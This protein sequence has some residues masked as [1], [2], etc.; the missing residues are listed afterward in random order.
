[1]TTTKLY[2]GYPARTLSGGRL[3]H[4]VALEMPPIA[5]A[6]RER[7]DAAFAQSF[8]GLTTDGKPRA[9]LYPLQR[10]GADTQAAV[11]AATAFLAGIRRDDHRRLVQQT[12]DGADRRRWTNAFP[13]WAPQ[14]VLLAD[15]E[16]AS[17]DAALAVVA[18]TLSARGFA[19]ARRIMHAN[20]A[21][22]EFLN[23]STDTL[24]EYG[25]FFTI[26]GQPAADAAWGWRLMG[27]HLVVH[28]TFVADQLVL[29][30]AFWGTEMSV[31]DE[32][33]HAGQ[34]LFVEEQRLGLELATSLAAN[35]RAAAI[36]HPSMRSSELPKHL[37]GPDGR[38][39]GGAGQDNRVVAP[40]GIAAESLSAGQRELLTRLMEVYLGRAAEPHGSLA[41]RAALA[42]LGETRFAWIGDPE[43]C[44]F[45][46]RIHGPTVW[47]EF[48]HHSG[49]FLA[50]P[51][52]EPFHIH[53]VV[54]TPNG[55]DYGADLLRQH[56]AQHPHPHG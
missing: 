48:D 54:R 56:Y 32:G 21:L 30:P 46:Y 17:R 52:P 40:E 20:Q 4:G 47:I 49:V 8:V 25:F 23:H 2:R 11:S 6:M 42:H 35:Q 18:A 26:Y 1:M 43:K 22:G 9:G 28:A 50:N 55:N 19:D 31:I 16:P 34:Q 14:G 10:T 53:T 29:T 39:L 41:M 27:N 15:F 33:P 36:L 5:N 44:P 45:Y 7:L 51:E 12:F 13:H 38:H 3:H 24:C 37:T